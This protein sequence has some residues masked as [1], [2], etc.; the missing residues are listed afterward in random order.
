MQIWCKQIKKKYKQATLD[1]KKEN[2][3]TSIEQSKYI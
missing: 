1:V 3:K 2:D